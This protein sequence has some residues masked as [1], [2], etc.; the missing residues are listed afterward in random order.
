[1]CGDGDGPRLR[2]QG[3]PGGRWHWRWSR[4]R[5]SNPEPAVYK[6]A[7]LP[8]ELRRRDGQGHTADDPIRR[9]EMIGPPGGMG[10]AWGLAGRSG[11]V[12]GEAGPDPATPAEPCAL[13]VDVT[14]RRPPADPPS[15]RFSDHQSRFDRRE[16]SI[17]ILPLDCRLEVTP[18][19]HGETQHLASTAKSA[20]HQTL[21]GARDR[22]PGG[23]ADGGVPGRRSSS[24]G[25]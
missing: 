10:Q 18:R 6:T 3:G 25:G 22:F 15:A 4:R 1:M 14:T 21:R 2:S 13:S 8:I 11:A 5:D 16:A 20:P 17:S 19:A 9:R 7:A 23:A 12:S 24:M